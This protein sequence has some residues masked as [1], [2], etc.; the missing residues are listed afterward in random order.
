METKLIN[1]QAPRTWILL[2]GWGGD[3]NSL[4]PLINS[5]APEDN[6]LA[7]EGERFL[8]GKRCFFR[9]NTET[10][11]FDLDGLRDASTQITQTIQRSLT[12]ASLQKT[13]KI[14]MGFSNGAMQLA[15]M[16]QDGIALAPLTF[17]MRPV[18]V[19]GD[20][21]LPR[22]DGSQVIIHNGARDRIIDNSGVPEMVQRFEQQGMIVINQTF[23]GG[24]YLSAAELAALKAEVPHE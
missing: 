14:A 6:L 23:D 10:H 22:M 24:H 11:W 12:Q 4:I 7:L 8:G 18:N 2:H 9:M 17:L 1:R 19:T 13:Q 20:F 21:P 5:I 16:L 3:R 15:G